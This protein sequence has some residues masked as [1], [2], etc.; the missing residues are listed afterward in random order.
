VA[1]VGKIFA[2]GGKRPSRVVFEEISSNESSTGSNIS[3]IIQRDPVD[4]KMRE[5]IE[6][7]EIPRPTLEVFVTD[8]SGKVIEKL[9]DSNNPQPLE[10]FILN[11]KTNAN[12]PFLV[13]IDLKN[14]DK[15]ESYSAKIDGKSIVALK[16]SK[17]NSIKKGIIEF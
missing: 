15:S 4:P 16:S 8:S 1:E 11:S 6:E 12:T 9:I 10:S 13:K 17:G 3:L 14:G 7:G 5:E 2:G